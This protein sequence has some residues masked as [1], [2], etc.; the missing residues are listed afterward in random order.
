MEMENLRDRQ[1]ELL[2][3]MEN[4]GY[5]KDYI[6]KIRREIQRIL[7][8][9]ATKKCASYK[10]VYMNYLAKPR[11]SSFL[12]DK[13]TVIS[14]IEQFDI[15]DRY[16][17]G[18]RRRPIVERGAY[19]QLFF[20]FKELVD[21]YRIVE[22]ERGKKETTIY[23]EYH[24]AATFLLALQD[25]GIH[26]LGDVTEKAV[27][28]VFV[29]KDG[30]Q[31]RSRSYA[32]NISAVFTACIPRYPYECRKI[33]SF[34]PGAREGRKNIQ[35][36]TIEEAQKIRAALNDMSNTLTMCDR[37][38]G[39]LA[40]Y[41]GLRGCDIAAMDMS[42]ID[43]D[44]DALHIQQQKTGVLLELPLS[45]IVGNA[46][47]DYLVLERPAASTPILFLTQHR[48]YRGMK[49]RSIW[50]VASRIL[51]AAGIRQSPGDRKGLHIFR[52]HLATTLLRNEVSQAVISRTL[53]HSSPNS[54]EA[55]LSADFP[56]LK[57]CAL[58]IARFP[59][60]EGVLVNE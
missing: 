21:Y 34:I 5:S 15:Y 7:T 19:P 30:E 50:N 16:P 29:S 10:Q 33:L 43:W 55:Y 18:T 37:A 51:R 31:R 24:N 38:I 27:M 56:H 35:Y 57:E 36:L 1:D 6:S 9:S 39:T 59:F 42:S 25:A 14:L 13:R 20:Q 2:S 58:D 8:G 40:F 26:C 53:G 4:G 48:H 17:D 46:I 23:T 45:P 22:L 12:R 60:P 52:H 28:E 11:S 49:A 41:T 32:K 44:R 3:Y 54:T 47:Y